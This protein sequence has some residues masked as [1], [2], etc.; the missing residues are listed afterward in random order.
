MK[1]LCL[2]L[3]LLGSSLS[4]TKTPENDTSPE[5]INLGENIEVSS[6]ILCINGTDERKLNGEY[7]YSIKY[8][9]KIKH[10]VLKATDQINV[11]NV[12]ICSNII[13]AFAH[14][15]DQEFYYNNL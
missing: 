13:I 2:S 11:F 5:S 1:L 8:S 10:F 15:K 7:L 3:V 12:S 14:A 9:Y 6:N 4:F